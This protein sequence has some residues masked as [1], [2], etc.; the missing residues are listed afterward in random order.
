[1]T[2]TVIKL[3]R[4]FCLLPDKT[5]H[6]IHVFIV[7]V[8]N[9]YRSLDILEQ[10][11]NT[12]GAGLP[13]LKI[14]KNNSLWLV[15]GESRPTANDFCAIIEEITPIKVGKFFLFFILMIFIMKQ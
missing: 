6:I 9:R 1:M 10:W 8:Q 14:K 12:H 15:D 2:S 7:R 11:I 4:I 5:A 3:A 13:L